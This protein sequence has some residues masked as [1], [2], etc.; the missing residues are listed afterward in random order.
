MQHVTKNTAATR[1]QQKKNNPN[2][3]NN[4]THKPS[5]GAVEIATPT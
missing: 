2:P 3:K 5:C 4:A 1:R